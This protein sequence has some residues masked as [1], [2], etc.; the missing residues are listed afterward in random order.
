MAKTFHLL[1]VC[2]CA[3][4]ATAGCRLS[5]VDAQSEKLRALIVDGQN[6][7]NWRACSPVLK[8][9]LEETGIFRVD[10]ATSPDK[11]KSTPKRRK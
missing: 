5:E 7:H 9:M 2:C 11:G 4:L 1:L 3:I 10:T 8:I 6:N